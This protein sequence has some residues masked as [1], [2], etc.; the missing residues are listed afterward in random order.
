MSASSL[1]LLLI[2]SLIVLLGQIIGKEY[3]YFDRQLLVQGQYWR[4]LTAHLV[5][6]NNIHLLLNVCAL[7]LVLMLFDKLLTVRAYI[8]LIVL[9]ACVQSIAFYYLL[10]NV[11]TYV[12]LSGVLHTLYVAATIQLLAQTKERV[13]ASVLLM[14]VTLKLLTENLGQGISVSQAM[15]NSRVLVEAHLYGAMI[16]VLAGLGLVLLK[17][18]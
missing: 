1:R 17:K 14:L 9:S 5:H 3:F 2:L 13:M 18:P 10:P 11:E 7:A 4:L 6:S 8:T 15:I 12:G 16:G